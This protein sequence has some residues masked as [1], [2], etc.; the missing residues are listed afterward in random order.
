MCSSDLVGAALI[1]P[2]VL[3][4]LTRV[5]KKLLTRIFKIEGQL[6]NANLAGAIPRLSI[7]VAAL[8]ISLSMMVAIAVMIGS[9]RTTVD[10]WIG[11]TLQ[12]DLYLRPATRA[13]I[14]VDAAVS[15]E[16]Q[17]IIARHPAVAAID[18]FRNFDL[19]YEDELITLGAGDFEVLLNYG[20]LQFKQPRNNEQAR[21]AMRA[22]IGTNNVLVSESF[23]IKRNKNIGDE[24][25]LN[26]PKG[27]ASF[28]VTGIYFDYSSDRGIVV[29]EIGR[30]SCR[31]RVYSSV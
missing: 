30:A 25:K 4:V 5:S 20:H 1:V 22:A 8:A 7:S 2:V 12:A 19:P 11:Q 18:R 16:V 3:F 23:A 31:E 26:T 29:L 14:T 21:A 28:R 10:Y 15:P 6:A 9:F 27:E 13:N 24:V 17:S